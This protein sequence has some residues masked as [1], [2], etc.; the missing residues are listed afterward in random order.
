MIT[1]AQGFRSSGQ[2]TS[3]T[4]FLTF[5]VITVAVGAYLHMELTM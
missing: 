3:H 2:C 1:N 4:N 5:S